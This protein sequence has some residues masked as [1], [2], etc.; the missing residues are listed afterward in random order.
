M[1]GCQPE[2]CSW[3]RLAAEITGLLGGFL[4]RQEASHS[5]AANGAFP[6]SH[7]P[8]RGSL[9]DLRRLNLALRPTLNAITFEIHFT[10]R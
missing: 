6:F 4:P 7:L 8:A 5:R 1:H 9:F 10:P 2:A 3:L